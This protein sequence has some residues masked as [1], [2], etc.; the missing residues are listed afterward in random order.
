MS[1]LQEK[2]REV[3][4]ISINA[5]SGDNSQPWRFSIKENIV[6]VFNDESKT[7]PIFDSKQYGAY[8]GHGCLLKNIRESSLS[9][10][11]RADITY[12]PEKDLTL[13]AKIEFSPAVDN[14][15]NLAEFIEKRKT[16]R[17]HY[18]NQNLSS[19]ERKLLGKE[20]ILF[21]E[22]E[23][24]EIAAKHLSKAEKIVF[25]TK[26]LQDII[27]K[28][29]VWAPKVE[30]IKKEGLFIKTLELNPVQQQMLK[31]SQNRSILNFL[32]KIG[33]S[34]LVGESNKETYV[35]SSAIG[36]IVGERNPG[37]F[38]SVGETL[39]QV[40]LEAISIG[41]NL[42]I[43]NGFIFMAADL[44]VM[45]EKTSISKENTTL[46]QEGLL[47]LR[48]VLNLKKENNILCAFRV[49]YPKKDASARSSKH[50]IEELLHKEG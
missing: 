44:D 32:N 31:L 50:I 8:I 15:S 33:F 25:E 7:N 13:I 49:G 17:N 35:A 5:P 14:F 36:F 2:I 22:G 21:L 47:E 24:K 40:W 48:E 43:I 1:N 37:S 9:A 28:S 6:E 19:E 27:F 42:Q 34:K 39:E 20:N 12:F 30:K 10:G 4:S 38:L 26:E 45:N 16:N 3:L 46:L 29:L 18:K 23:K 41:M 11:L